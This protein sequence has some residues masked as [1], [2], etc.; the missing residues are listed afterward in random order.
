LSFSGIDDDWGTD[1]E[2]PQ[3]RADGALKNPGPEHDRDVRHWPVRGQFPGVIRAMEGRKRSS[4][5]WGRASW[6]R[7]MAVV[8]RAG[9]GDAES[10]RHY[11]FSAEK[12]SV[13][14]LGGQVD[15]ILVVWQTLVQGAAFRGVGPVMVSRSMR[16]YL[17]PFTPIGSECDFRWTR[18]LIVL[19]LVPADS[20]TIGKFICYG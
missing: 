10:R 15:V 9:R 13:R 8:V 5:G 14:R 6:R 20:Q 1:G 7:W 17:Y 4:S 11:V 16:G 18:H 3:E 2:T 19:L 12:A